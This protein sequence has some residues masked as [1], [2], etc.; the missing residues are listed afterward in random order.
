MTLGCGIYRH[1][2]QNS[3]EKLLELGLNVA[4]CVVSKFQAKWKIDGSE[5]GV[6]QI[7]HLMTH[8]QIWLN[9]HEAPI[10]WQ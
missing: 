10:E 3:E 1:S 7:R 9:P 4:S 2:G 8:S 5:Q 6:G